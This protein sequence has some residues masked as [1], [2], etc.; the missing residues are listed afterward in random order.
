MC[1][2]LNENIPSGDIVEGSNPDAGKNAMVESMMSAV[3]LRYPLLYKRLTACPVSFFS[4][5][6]KPGKKFCFC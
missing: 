5:L 4:S 6:Y 1:T 2:D 3:D